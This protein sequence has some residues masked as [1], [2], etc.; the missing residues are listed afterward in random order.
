MPSDDMDDVTEEE[1]SEEPEE[2]LEPEAEEEDILL[3]EVELPEGGGGCSAGTWVVI[4]IILA[5]LVAL[6][7]WSVRRSQEEAKRRDAE[8]R[9][10]TRN[11]MLHD[12]GGGI[13]DAEAAIQRGDMAEAVDDL[14]AME[15]KLAAAVSAAKE[16]RDTEDAS[17][18]TTMRSAVSK[19]LDDIRTKHDEL[20]K[21][22]ATGVRE[23]R[24]ALGEYAPPGPGL[25]ESGES[26][27]AP[28]ETGEGAAPEQGETAEPAEGEAGAGKEPAEPKAGD[29]E[30]APA[31]AARG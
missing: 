15:E 10:R 8:D 17:K 30:P 27:A 22:A 23:V 12:I 6:G 14:E 9:Q 5:A 18:I 16:A 26:G 29:V 13:K 28:T 2:E 3:G 24:H 19:V 25:S 4:I 21:A 31:E 20:Q 11:T 7:V 1:T